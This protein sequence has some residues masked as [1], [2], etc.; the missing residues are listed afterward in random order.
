MRMCFVLISSFIWIFTNGWT[1]QRLEEKEIEE[2]QP[3]KNTID[4]MGTRVSY[5][6]Y[7]R[8]ISI[9]KEVMKM[10]GTIRSLLETYDIPELAM[11]QYW[12]ELLDLYDSTKKMLPR[13]YLKNIDGEDIIQT[14]AIRN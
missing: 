2:E 11:N 4:F 10:D 14:D 1:Q 7:L 6:Q 13:K 8:L 3:P 9:Q 12:S 5:P